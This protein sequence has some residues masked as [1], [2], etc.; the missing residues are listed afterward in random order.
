[1]EPLPTRTKITFAIRLATLLAAS[2]CASSLFADWQPYEARYAL[3][4]NG[5]LAGKVEISLTREGDSWTMRSEGSGTHGL[6]RIL[7]AKDIENVV[8]RFENGKFFPEHYTSHTR[9]AGIDN[10]WSANFDWTSNLVEIVDGKNHLSL[11]MGP[12]A[13]DALSL[14]LEMQ[15]RLRD[16]ETGLNFFLVDEDEIKDQDFQMLKSERLETSLGC[17]DTVPVER[18]RKNSTRYTRGWHA[19][20][21]EFITVRVEHG[22]TDG[23]HMEMRITELV[24]DGKVVDPQPGCAALQ[25]SQE[26]P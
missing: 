2:V 18:V 5:K 22:K 4:R 26:T 9:V 24:I 19:P 12:G 14:K 21:L 13:L 8:G 17:L 7:R 11:D 3:Y 20:D 6:A 23:D 10:E 1:M 15:R 16:Q 25:I